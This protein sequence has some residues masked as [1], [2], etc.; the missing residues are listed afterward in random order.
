MNGFLNVLK[1][2]DMSSAAVVSCIRRITG[3]KVGH[4]GTL[5]PQAAGILPIMIGRATQ[6]F[7]YLVDKK[8]EYIAELAFGSSTDT[9][10]AQGTVIE[11]CTSFPEIRDIEKALK[12]FTGPLMQ[13]PPAYSA[14]KRNG[15]ALYSQAR[16][17]NL[18]ET[19]AR[20][21]DINSI[22]L[23]RPMPNNG[24]LLRIECGKGVY[25]RTLCHDLGKYLGCPAHMR[26]LLRTSTGIFTLSDAVIM[27]ELSDTESISRHLM[28]PDYPLQYMPKASIP[29]LYDK[30]CRN[31]VKLSIEIFPQLRS[32]VS[33]RYVRL[34][35]ECEF[36]GIA[37]LSSDGFLHFR[38]M[39]ACG[40]E[41][42]EKV[43]ED[44]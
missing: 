44:E 5:D 40:S 17:G 1:P 11:K 34:Y 15:I 10:D 38:T 12:A 6:L 20:P 31:G 7:D 42:N 33:G 26:F 28:A 39:M 18:V 30:A 37:Q 29:D 22:E 35:R 21:V 3:G 43:L 25:I 41:K 13:R 8:K 2:P 9:Q 14:I 32:N 27:E 23:V 16:R 24:Y 19:E 4:A 36:M